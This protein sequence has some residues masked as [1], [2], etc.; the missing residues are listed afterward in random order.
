[1]LAYPTPKVGDVIYYVSYPNEL[2]EIQELYDHQPYKGKVC[3]KY[4][5][6]WDFLDVLHENLVTGKVIRRG[7]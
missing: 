1:M 2:L 5:D 3:V 7:K 6:G 4:S